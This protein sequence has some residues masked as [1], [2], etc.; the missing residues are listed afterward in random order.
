M[1]QRPAL[2]IADRGLYESASLQEDIQS[3]EWQ[4]LLLAKMVCGRYQD[5]PTLLHWA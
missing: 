5:S 4:K 2:A 1:R 3:V